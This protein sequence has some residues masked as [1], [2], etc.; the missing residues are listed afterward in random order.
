VF[1]VFLILAIAVADAAPQATPPPT[2][3]KVRSR[4]LC[5]T[6]RENIAPALLALSRNEHVIDAGRDQLLAMGKDRVVGATD[7]WRR[8]DRVRLE[9]LITPI[10]TN[11]ETVDKLL[12]DATKFPNQPHT[13]DDVDAARMKAQLLGIL[14]QQKAALNVLNGTVETQDLADM[15]ALPGTAND[16][17]VDK[18]SDMLWNADVVRSNTTS[19]GKTGSETAQP[20][21]R[22][23]PVGLVGMT[24]FGRDAA[25]VGMYQ[26]NMEAMGQRAAATIF[27]VA[28]DCRASSTPP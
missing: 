12:E 20:D 2:I 7:G 1:G 19:G 17:S 14:S 13:V 9:N 6:L 27:R 3:A 10:E 26:I 25:G 16:V 21:T 28:A 23:R 8:L 24:T 22:A 15:L 11:I 5:S 18:V 4:A